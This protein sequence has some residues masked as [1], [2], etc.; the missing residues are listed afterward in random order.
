MSHYKLRDLA[1][2]TAIYLFIHLF[3]GLFYLFISL[4]N[5]FTLWK[6]VSQN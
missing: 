5:Y 4:L 2:A 3:A 6:L 1:T